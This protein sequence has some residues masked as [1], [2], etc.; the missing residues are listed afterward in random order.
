MPED[1]VQLLAKS[2]TDRAPPGTMLSFEFMVLA[3]FAVILIGLVCGSIG[4]LVVGNRMAFFSDALAHCAFAGVALGL[5]LGFLAGAGADQFERWLTLIMVAFGICMGLLIAIVKDKTS[6]AS[7]TVIGVFFA[8]AIG[9]GAIF[10]KAGAQRRFMPPED[11]LFGTLIQLRPFEI[12]ELALLLLVAVIAL[13]L[14]YNRVV[15]ASFNASLAQSRGISVRACNYLFIILL[16]LIVNVC[17][18]TVGV[19][20]INALL[21]VPA[22]TAANLARNMR[23]LFALAMALCVLCGVGGLWISWEIHQNTNFR[24]GES[25]TIVVLAVLL[26][27]ISV[28]ANPLLRTRGGMLPGGEP[29]T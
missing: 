19:L 4:S 10:L 26:Y 20:L 18:K 14:I 22:A 1:L 2:I 12:V 16:A 5:M 25:G 6:Q 27:S 11:F 15:F 7:D 8:G 3:L 17:L 24:P 13:A 9:L 23:E 29:A 21:I 28:I